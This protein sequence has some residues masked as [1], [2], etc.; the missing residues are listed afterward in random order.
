MPDEFDTDTTVPLAVESFCALKP[1]VAAGVPMGTSLGV[2]VIGGTVVV[3]VAVVVVVGGAVVV[4]GVD[5]VVEITAVLEVAVFGVASDEVGA[6]VDVVVVDVGS[7]T[8]GAGAANAFGLEA[9]TN[10]ELPLHVSEEKRMTV[11]V[12]VILKAA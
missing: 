5:V 1:V 8:A 6:V 12:L 7:V 9:F 10:V 3:V 11:V 2:V 4:D